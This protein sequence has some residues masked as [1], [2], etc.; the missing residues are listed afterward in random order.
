[1]G[2]VYS[3]DGGDDRG[4]FSADFEAS[5]G[6]RHDG[7]YGGRHFLLQ[8]IVFPSFDKIRWLGH[9]LVLE[10]NHHSFPIVSGRLGQMP[11][12]LT[13]G[14]LHCGTLGVGPCASR[15]WWR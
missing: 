1:M 11:L 7:Q 8:K 3:I 5:L 10:R 4:K 15:T 2:L 6:G 12:S 9:F 13:S 14:N